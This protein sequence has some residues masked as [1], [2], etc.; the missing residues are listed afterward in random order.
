MNATNKPKPVDCYA[1]DAFK[2]DGRHIERGSVLQQLDGE[3]AIELAGQ[4]RVR[5]A[6]EDEVAEATRK[7][8]K[9]AEA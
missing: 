6:T 9:K 1:I 3:L 7:L 5:A 8:A 4:G 2:I